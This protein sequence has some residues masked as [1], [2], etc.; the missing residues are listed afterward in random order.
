[1]IIW[2]R[3]IEPGTHTCLTSI[4]DTDAE[5]DVL[6]ALLSG[7]VKTSDLPGLMPTAFWSPFNGTVY[8]AIMEL[9]EA[10]RTVDEV[11]VLERVIALSWR[12]SVEEMSYEISL[13]KSC[14]PYCL[15]EQVISQAGRIVSLHETRKLVILLEGMLAELKGGFVTAEEAQCR[16]KN[17]CH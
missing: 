16:L 13:I 8:H 6:S 4:Y 17:V 3:P 11:S 9:E 7:A 12:G 10:G 15:P 2:R 14:T 1:M 5:Q